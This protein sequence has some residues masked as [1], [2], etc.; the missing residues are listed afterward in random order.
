MSEYVML[1]QEM[2]DMATTIRKYLPRIT[3]C[4]EE[5]AKDRNAKKILYTE[6]KD[7]KMSYVLTEDIAKVGKRLT[8]TEESPLVTKEDVEYLTNKKT[9][10]LEKKGIDI[11][12]MD[13]RELNK[14]IKK[15]PEYKRGKS[16]ISSLGYRGEE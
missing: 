11:S 4:L 1:Q 9:D 10:M 15:T 3:V 8:E 16:M 5:I 6:I 14:A 2:K 13:V 7:T 12:K